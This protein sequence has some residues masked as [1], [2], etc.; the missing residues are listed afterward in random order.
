MHCYRR[1]ASRE[2]ATPRY[3]LSYV[4]L[5]DGIW[6]LLGGLLCTI[7]L[8][9]DPTATYGSLTSF[10]PPTIDLLLP[11]RTWD[12]L[13]GTAPDPADTP[14]GE[15]LIAVFDDW[16]PIGRRLF[17]AFMQPIWDRHLRATL[18]A[19]CLRGRWSSKHT[20]R[21]ARWTA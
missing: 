6:H 21:L 4:D 12:S 3:P 9:N 2:I 5:Q 10:V 11:H 19:C 1:F 14:Y 20:A 15:W 7:D 8:R 17:V 13:T 18:L 16:Y